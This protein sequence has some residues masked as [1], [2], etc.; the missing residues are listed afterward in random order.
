M[1]T[2]AHNLFVVDCLTGRAN[3]L[4]PCAAA[5]VPCIDRHAEIQAGGAGFAWPEEGDDVF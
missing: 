5:A 4:C 3:A 1:Q 2:A